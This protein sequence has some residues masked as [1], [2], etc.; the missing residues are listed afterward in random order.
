MTQ[1]PANR[2]TPRPG[3]KDT[4]LG[5]SYNK[6]K[7]KFVASAKVNGKIK[8]IGTYPTAELAHEAYLDCL[9]KHGVIE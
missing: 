3:T 1:L 8:H 7:K 5:V 2:R 6:S 9:R 4:P